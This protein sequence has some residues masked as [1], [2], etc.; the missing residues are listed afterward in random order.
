MATIYTYTADRK[1]PRNGQGPR[2]TIGAKI[3]R[4]IQFKAQKNE[5]R[6]AQARHAHQIK[7][8]RGAIEQS[9]SIIHQLRYELAKMMQSFR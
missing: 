6:Q 7:M 2:K 1:R 3:I 4:L 5:A 8:H 9:E